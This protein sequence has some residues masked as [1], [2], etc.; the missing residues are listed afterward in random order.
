MQEHY[1]GIRKI[2]TA[3]N[4]VELRLSG[5]TQVNLEDNTDASDDEANTLSEQFNRVAQSFWRADP[6]IIFS[7]EI[8]SEESAEFALEAAR[9]GHLCLSTIHTAATTDVPSRFD[10]FNINRNVYQSSSS[11]TCLVAQ[12]LVRTVC[13]SCGRKYD[14]MGKD[15]PLVYKTLQKLAKLELLQYLG[16]IRFANKGG[17]ED[18]N[19]S[20]DGR[21]GRTLVAEVLE[22]D[23]F[24]RQHWVDDEDDLAKKHWLENGG[25][26]KLEHAIYKLCKGELDIEIIESEIEEIVD[27][28]RI[29]EELGVAP[30]Q[31]EI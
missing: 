4:P 16:E 7:G 19:Y 8:R 24:I 18:C 13:K 6:D 5:T 20:P 10:S 27:S 17:C 30:Y 14:E 1:Q 26:T 31:P 23:K 3:E 25:F 2:L 15:S 22:A 12:S 11:L 29:R 21:K 28:R 9:T